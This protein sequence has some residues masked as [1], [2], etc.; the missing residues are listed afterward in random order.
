MEYTGP[1]AL[2]AFM[3]W[4]IMNMYTMIWYVYH[5]ATEV[6]DIMPNSHI[7]IHKKDQLALP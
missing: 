4:Y 2:A 7:K 1:P 6:M 5:W 3:I